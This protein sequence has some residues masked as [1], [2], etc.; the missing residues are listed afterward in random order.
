MYKQRL[1]EKLHFLRM[2]RIGITNQAIANQFSISPDN[3]AATL[4]GRSNLENLDSSKPR[5]RNLTLGTKIRVLYLM[6]VHK[7][8]SLVRHVCKIHHKTVEDILDSRSRLLAQKVKGI[9][10]S[11]KRPI[12]A[13]YPLME[14]EVLD[15][16]KW[17]RSERF[18]VTNYHIKARALRAATR[19]KTFGFRASNGWLQ[20]FIHCSTFQRSFKIH[21]KGGLDLPTDAT[22]RMQEIRNI[23]SYY[24]LAKI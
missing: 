10:I 21:A 4:H 1:S 20:N 2:A 7:N 5:C 22:V 15:F 18:S 16:I 8:Q 6:D 14:A 11:V 12:K 9:P 17:V 3:V 24:E 23:S 13:I 19:L